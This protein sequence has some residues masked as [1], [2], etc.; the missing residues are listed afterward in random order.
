MYFAKGLM[1]RFLVAITLTVAMSVTSIAQSRVVPDKD[2]PK[3]GNLSSTFLTGKANS[4]VPVPFGFDELNRDSQSPITGSVSRGKP[5]FWELKV[6]NNSKEATYSVDVEVRQLDES[7]RV[8]K[9]DYFTYTLPPNG[10]KSQ[11]ITDGVN[12]KGA[13]LELRKFT[14]LSAK[15]KVS[16][17]RT[18]ATPTSK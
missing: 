18:A 12:T 10:S 14:N 9:R 3:S 7:L 17:S 5:G 4:T 6:F 16:A 1:N 11:M 2:L 15:K 8:V 13:E